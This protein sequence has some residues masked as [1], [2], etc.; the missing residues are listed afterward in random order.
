MAILAE[1]QKPKAMEIDRELIALM[2]KAI[3]LD[4][5]IYSMQYS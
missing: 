5:I 1:H 2:T 3:A 4:G